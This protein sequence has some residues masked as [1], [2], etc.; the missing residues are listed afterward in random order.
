MDR[1]NREY[2]ALVLEA[3]DLPDGPLKV[4]LLSEAVRLADADNDVMRGFEARLM[5][6]PAAQMA[7][8]PHQ[9]VVA[10]TWCLAQSDRDPET[11]PAEDLMWRYRWVVSQLPHFPDVSRE[12]I[13]ESFTDMSQRYAAMGASP[14]PVHLLKMFLSIRLRDIPAGQEAWRKCVRSRHDIWCDSTRTEKAFRLEY[15]VLAKRYRE[16]VAQNPLVVAGFVD[17][18]HFFALDAADILKPLLELGRVEDALRVQQA[19]YR[20]VAR[21]PGKLDGVS[22]HLAFF[23]RLDDFPKALKILREN[24]AN[25]AVAPLLMDRFD[26]LLATRLLALR[27]KRAG[28]EAMKVKLPDSIPLT[29]GKKGYDLDELAEWIREDLEPIAARFDARNGN[30]WFADTMAAIPEL[31]ER[32]APVTGSA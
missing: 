2:D 9:L 29:A 24:I 19:G 30:S 4:N 10:F 12:Q 18:R 23:A 13:D 22:R 26:I 14:R 20:L 27:M 11:F 25:L 1:K 6:M 17:D 31:A 3:D 28:H 32:P 5:L 16:A 8:L 15:L 21:D 7:S